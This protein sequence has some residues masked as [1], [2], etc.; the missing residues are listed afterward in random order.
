MDGLASAEEILARRDDLRARIAASGADP[1]TVTVVA[2]TKAFPAAV[3]GRALD[4][5]L[6]DLGENYAQELVAKAAWLEDLVEGDASGETA[7][8]AR[9]RWH[10][11]GGLQRNKVRL[12]AP[13]VALWH[14]VDRSSLVA[15]IAKRAPGARI[16]VQVNTTSEHQKSGC[17][18]ADAPAL[19]DS[20]RGLGLDVVGLMTVGPAGSADPRPCFSRLRQLGQ[21][22]S[23][24]ELSMGMSGDLESAIEE[25]A[26]MIRVGTALFGARP[27]R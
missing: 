9:P 15:E 24:Q 20:A 8:R 6:Y 21:Q 18:P 26:T 23:L 16:L 12:L 7:G 1:D 25:G 2:V 10:F 14:S 11:I 17:A 27:Q 5:G 4:A 19:V 13:H 22:L 3:V